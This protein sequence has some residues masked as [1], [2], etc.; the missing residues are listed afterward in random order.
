MIN[1][2]RFPLRRST[3]SGTVDFYFIFKNPGVFHGFE[4]TGQ[5]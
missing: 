2:G 4:L 1:N 3:E 5:N